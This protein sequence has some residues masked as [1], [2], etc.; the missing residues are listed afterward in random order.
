MLG[1]YTG[2]KIVWVS[3]QTTPQRNYVRQQGCATEQ[4]LRRVIYVGGSHKCV[5]PKSA[6]RPS[7]PTE[8]VSTS[9]TSSCA[10]PG[11]GGRATESIC[12]RRGA[13]P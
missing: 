8:P 1:K 9:F 3:K 2:M 7:H 11:G 5:A 10:T 12:P 13:G 6:P 4:K